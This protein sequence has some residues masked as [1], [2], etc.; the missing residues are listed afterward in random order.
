MVIV[1]TLPLLTRLKKVALPWHKLLGTLL[2]L[3]L[4][5]TLLTGMG[6][7][8]VKEIG[9]NKALGKTILHLHTLQVIG[10]HKV[11]PLVLGLS[12]LALLLTAVVL[13]W[14]RR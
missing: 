9:G 6:F 7:T 12:L 10:L 2:L 8:L 14:R 5:W 11:Y 1:M 4:T 13:L 3:P